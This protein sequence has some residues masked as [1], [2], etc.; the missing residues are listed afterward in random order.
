MGV[1]RSGESGLLWWCEFNNSVSTRDGRRRDES[2]LKDET[3]T[4]RSSWF[5]GKEV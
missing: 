4:S 1:G 2:L 3:E 5:N